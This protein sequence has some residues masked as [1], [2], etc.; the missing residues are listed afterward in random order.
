M[1]SQKHL[2]KR[3]SQFSLF[4]FGSDKIKSQSEI[5]HCSQSCFKALSQPWVPARLCQG[6]VS[7]QVRQLGLPSPRA[8]GVGFRKTPG[9][10]HFL[11]GILL[12]PKS[13]SQGFRILI[14]LTAV[15]MFLDLFL[16]IVIH[17]LSLEASSTEP[18]DGRTI[19][20]ERNSLWA[21]SSETSF[22]F[23]GL[24]ILFH[25]QAICPAV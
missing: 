18:P 9:E 19:V 11:A 6:G 8:Q 20:T 1:P 12:A 23:H 24:N 22:L 5:V 21:G 14:Q 4:P 16:P 25:R 3:P 15:T 17:C 7:M 10:E 2:E 13:Q